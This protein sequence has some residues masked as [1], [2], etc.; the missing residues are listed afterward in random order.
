MGEERELYGVLEGKL[1]GKRPHGRPRCIWENG[2]RMDL[3]EIGRRGGVDS[4]GLG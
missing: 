3:R 4:V 1:E 2:I